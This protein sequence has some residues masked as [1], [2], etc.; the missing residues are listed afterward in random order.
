MPH[1]LHHKCK[2]ESWFCEWLIQ[3]SHGL[4]HQR[5]PSGVYSLAQ[6]CSQTEE[7]EKGVHFISIAW[8]WRS[9]YL[10]TFGNICLHSFL[11]QYACSTP[12]HKC[13]GSFRRLPFWFQECNFGY[14]AEVGNA[15]QQIFWSC[16]KW[17]VWYV[18]VFSCQS[19]G[20]L[21]S[22][23]LLMLILTSGKKTLVTEMSGEVLGC[24]CMAICHPDTS[25]CSLCTI[26][27]MLTLS[28]RCSLWLSNGQ[29]YHPCH[30]CSS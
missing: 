23:Y 13:P 24:L 10:I 30:R 21:G 27:S 4:L 3:E 14:Q 29:R 12:L 9:K 20:M 6:H 15:R 5:Y 2:P 25:K 28:N 11:W 18:F 19:H 17:H 7:V 16:K 22:I 26:K 1:V 8:R